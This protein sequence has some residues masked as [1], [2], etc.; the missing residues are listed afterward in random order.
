MTP[1]ECADAV[2][3][4]IGKYGTSWMLAPETFGPGIEAGFSGLDFYFCGRA[5]AMGDVHADVVVASIALLGPEATRSNWEA[6]RRVMPPRQAAELFA[7]AC[8]EHGRRTFP[9]DIDTTQLAQLAGSVIDAADCSGLPLFAA[10]RTM[11]VPPDPKGAA[12]H[13]LNVLREFRGGAHAAAVI[14]HGLRP[15]EASLVLGGTRNAAFLGHLEPYPDVTDDMKVAREAAERSTTTI[16]AP[17]FAA[18]SEPER[19]QFV[20]LVLGV[21]G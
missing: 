5:G 13:Q 20:E 10:W 19:E 4:P 9:D 16:V 17:A 2:A 3:L 6:G 7:E 11:P 8:A 15:V 21:V 1:E 18:L 12:S 14:S